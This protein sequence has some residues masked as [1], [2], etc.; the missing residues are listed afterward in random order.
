MEIETMG[1][2]TVEATI[3]NMKDAWAAEQGLVPIDQIRRI[4]VHDALVDT[5]AS[6]L[7]LP[8]RLIQQLGLARTGTRRFMSSV[9]A[10]E[11]GIYEVVRLTIQDRTC[12]VAVSEV[13]DGVPTLI[14][15]IPLEYLDF[16]V[17]LSGRKLIGN[18][19]HG[20]EWT[21]ELY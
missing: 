16:V 20:G 12:P 13:P 11:A 21:Y 14:G 6:M 15:Q 3:E 10:G 1:R 18:P 9:G 8:T 7:S 4:V 17:D 19:A 2:V 5:D